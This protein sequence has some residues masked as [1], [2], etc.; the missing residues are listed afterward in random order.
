M[1]PPRLAERLLR[2][3]LVDRDRDTISGDLLEEYREVAVPTRGVSGARWWYRR[4][5]AGLVWRALRLP[6]MIGLAIGA[7]LGVIN[8]I[9]TAR[10]PPR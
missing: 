1:T 3:L 9:D 2:L 5:V 10:H 4:Q 8:L 7:A 6:A